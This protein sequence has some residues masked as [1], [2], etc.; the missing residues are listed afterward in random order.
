MNNW[1][2][3]ECSQKNLCQLFFKNVLAKFILKPASKVL[4]LIVSFVLFGV[5]CWGLS[6]L[7]QEF[8]PEWFLPQNSYLFKFIM[9]KNEYFPAIGE[10]GLIYFGN[11]SL[12]SELHQIENIVQRLE[13]S[14]YIGGVNSWYS[15][16]KNYY[17]KQ[18]FLVPDPDMTE[19]QFQD[20]L[21]MFLYSSAG[22]QYR[23]K[24]FK[25][26]SPITCSEPAPRVL[27]SSIDFQYNRFYDTATKLAAMHAT[28]A[29]ASQSNI[30]D[31][32][33]DVFARIHS[34]L[35]TDEIIEHE[36]YRNLSLALLVVFLMT[37][38]LIASMLQSLLVLICVIMTMVDVGAL[39]HWWGL[40]IDTLSFIDLVLA[41]GLC[42]DYAAHVGESLLSYNKL[43][44]S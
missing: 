21:G 17:G 37:F 8:H 29:I 38:G 7:R 25:Y 6:N 41:I 24:N 4:V 3:N 18:G 1:E 19:E 42:V 43:A 32:F 16:Y 23:D 2:P 10:A 20:D 34:G 12:Y 36:L 14:E 35:E 13:S 30:T 44:V 22:A 27:A 33:V 39:M 40:T 11:I 9:K 5:S 15:S 31:G 26:A 28:K